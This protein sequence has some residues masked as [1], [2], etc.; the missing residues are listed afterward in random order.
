L[1]GIAFVLVVA[2]MS[3]DYTDALFTHATQQLFHPMEDKP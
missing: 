1:F 2:T 3:R